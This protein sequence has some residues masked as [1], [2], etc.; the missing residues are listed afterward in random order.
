M[1]H[2]VE[3]VL[4]AAVAALSVGAA[5]YDVAAYVW[6]AYHN[7][8]RW[9]ELGIFADGKGEWQNLYESVKRTQDDYQGV[10]PLW[11]YEDESDPVAVARK[12]DAATAAGVNVFIYD[13]YWY[14]GRPF[15]ED[16]LNKGFL[17]AKNCERM[18]FY[19]MYANH[20]VNRLWDNKVG[21]KA[22]DEI[23]WHAKISDADWCTIVARWINQYFARPNYY[24]IKGCPVLMIYDI[25]A[26]VR[27][28]GEA[29]AK[30]RIAYLRQETKKA[31]FPDVHLQ[32][33]CF[34][35]CPSDPGCCQIDLGADSMSIYNWLYKTSSRLNSKTE[36]ELNYR[37]WGEMSMMA[38]D[39]AKTAAAK[40][41]AVY[42]PNITVGWDTNARYPKDE[43]RNIVHGSNPA[44]F[45]DFARQVKAWADA[46]IPADMPKL[47]TVNSWNEWTEG[48]YLEPDD[49]FGYGYLNALWR[50]FKGGKDSNGKMTADVLKSRTFP[51]DYVKRPDSRA[52]AVNVR[53][54]T[55]VSS[56]A[57]APNGRLWATW[58]CGIAPAED[59]NNYVVLS[60]S[61]DDGK[62]WQEVFVADPDGAGMARSFDPEVWVAPDGSLR[63]LWTDRICRDSC[64]RR[65]Q[66]CPDILMMVTIP[67]ANV[68][69]DNP[70]QPRPIAEGVM[71]CK[72]TVLAN[73]TW[74]FPVAKWGGEPWSSCL[75]AS[76]DGGKTF[77]LRGGVKV[78][79]EDSEFD[80]H[81][82]MERKNGDLVCYSRAKSG[83]R[84]TV[85]NDGGFS[86]GACVKSKLPHPSARCFVRKLKSGAW[87]LVKNG[88]LDVAKRRSH[89]TAYVSDDEG[90][91]WKG[92]LLLEER[93]GCSYPD[94]QET[95][96]G[97][98]YITYDWDRYNAR[99]IYFCTFTE[100]DVRAGK[101]VSGKVRMRQVIS[102]GRGRPVVEP[103]Y[104][105]EP[106]KDHFVNLR[107]WS[108]DAVQVVTPGGRMWKTWCADA[109]HDRDS[110][111]TY[112]IL[113]TSTEGGKEWKEVLVVDPDDF[114]PR[115]PENVKLVLDGGK[116]VWSW[117]DRIGRNNDGAEQTW[118]L[119]LDAG[120]EPSPGVTFK[121]ELV[122]Q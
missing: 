53:A 103:G 79:Q 71:M 6:P 21:G 115:H 90:A 29:V 116:L 26:F 75:Y 12:I 56:M 88:G 39:V 52:Y 83:I 87:L 95:D 47:I 58:Y 31:G 41:G 98:I 48:T 73:G 3:I 64:G 35:F 70:P 122:N 96:D 23:V 69:P 101:P 33:L 114:W 82:F 119:V 100:E 63:W 92:G 34:A 80:E 28:D 102:Q 14:G 16:A 42:F 81:M 45:E 20:N 8:P 108:G 40:M 7:E 36:P 104:I 54:G 85:S 17:G 72:P 97:T 107:K 15:L 106:R 43:R 57:V 111:D 46:N 25:G 30:E 76:T 1:Y 50:V 49:K 113:A 11:G 27:W 65:D 112:A 74:A 118:N 51:A 9:A 4:F 89:L 44:D 120:K 99:M 2:K 19:I 84:E 93:N 24:K 105:G 62:T 66:T 38:A 78:P 94:G 13:W 86:W 32:I 60:T 18:K 59:H 68:V 110:Y 77:V 37:Q 55:L 91:T 121:A 22:K 67:D 10:K 61:M 117:V 109:K 5:E